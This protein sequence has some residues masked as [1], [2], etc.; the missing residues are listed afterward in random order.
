M[1]LRNTDDT[2]R[3]G[4]Q[5]GRF[6][7]RSGSLLF[8]ETKQIAVVRCENGFKINIETRVVSSLQSVH[9]SVTHFIRF[10]TLDENGQELTSASVN[11]DEV[12]EFIGAI[13]FV[14]N[15]AM[16]ILPE[17]RDYTE[18]TY[19]SKG[20][21]T[22]GFYQANNQQQAFIDAG[23]SNNL[24]FLTVEK[25]PGLRRALE[26]ASEHLISRGAKLPPMEI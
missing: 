25:L 15:L 14:H 26:S 2:C 20:S 17:S 19:T 1:S 21:M 7:A 24:V 12:E 10:A 16:Q 3:P 5:M 6:V 11:F 18:V 22:F 23:G 9:E 4:T 13:D 8:K